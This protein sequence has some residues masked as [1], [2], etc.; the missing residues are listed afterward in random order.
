M[1]RQTGRHLRADSHKP[2]KN[3]RKEK[4]FINTKNRQCMIKMS[5]LKKSHVVDEKR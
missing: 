4:D 1:M 3:K 2:V 5:Q